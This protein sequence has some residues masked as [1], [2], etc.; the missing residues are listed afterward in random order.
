MLV[1]GGG[2]LEG[3]STEGGREGVLAGREGGRKEEEGSQSGR[4]QTAGN[5]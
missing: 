2:G 1:E 5:T 3:M 4:G